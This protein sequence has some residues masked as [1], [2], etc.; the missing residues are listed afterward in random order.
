MLHRPALFL[1][2]IFWPLLTLQ[3]RAGATVDY[4]KEIRPLLEQKCYECHG[5]K[6]VKG[7]VDLKKLDGDPKFAT[8]YEVWEKVKEVITSGDMP[9][10]D[11]PA[12]PDA[13]RDK[14]LAWISHSLDDPIR[15]NAGDPGVVT[16]RR[17]TNSE[18]D[19]TLRDLTGLD[20]H[21][22]RDFAPDGGGGEGFTN[23]GDV[24][25]VSPQQLDKYFGAARKLADYATIMPG[26]GITFQKQR[27]GLRGPVQV[28]A[29]AEQG[30]YVWY[31]KMAEPI[32]PKDT[33]DAREADY[34][35]ACWKWKHRD[36]TGAVSLEQLAKDNGLM[37]PFLE[38]WWNL[39]TNVEPKSRYLDLTR[40]GWRQLPPPDAARP[41]EVPAAVRDRILALQADQRSWLGPAGKPGEGTQRHQQDSDGIHRYDF[42]A[43]VQGKPVVHIVLGDVAGDDNKGDWVTFDGLTL[44]HGKKKEA[45]LDWLQARL[46]A[47]K[48]ALAK[49]GA[50]AARLNARI[51]EAE[52]ALA[53]FGKDPRGGTARPDAIVAQ[54]PTVITLPLPEDATKFMA[55][56]KLDIDGPNAD[57]AGV[58]WMAT[59]DTPRD[60]HT[61]LPGILTVWK[62]GSSAT[63]RLGREFGIMKDAFPDEYLRRLE[64][65]ARNYERGGKGLGVYYLSDTQLL[66]LIPAEEKTH[67]EKMMADWKLVRSKEVSAPQGKEWDEAVKRHLVA[68]AT[69]A[70]RHDL[71]KDETAQITGLYEAARGRE[72]DRESAGREVLVRVLVSPN[73]LFK[74]EDATQPGIQPI[75][76]W[77]LAT[78]LSYF[79]WASA[80]DDALRAAAENGSLLKPEVLEQQAKRMLRDPRASALAEE[81]AGQWLKFNSFEDKAN[82]DAKKFPEFTP[83]LKHDMYRE[84]VEF[85][86][87]VIREDR[88][89]REIVSANYTFLNERL[90]KFYGIPGVTGDDFRL[91][92]VGEYQRGGVL[93]MGCLLA[94][95]SYPHRTSP[96]LRGNW[97]LVSV[98]G[99]PTPPPPNN[100][101]KLDDSVSAASTLRERLERHRQDKA[102]SVCHEKIDPLGFALEGFDP[103]GRAR[104]TDEAG[105]KIDN[106]GQ[107]KSSKPFVGVEGL[108]GF[109]A[110]HDKEFTTNFCRKLV[111][112]ALG[113]SLILTDKPLIE[114]MRTDLPKADDRFSVAVLDLVKSRQFQYRRND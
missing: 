57:L 75:T 68:F 84:T 16:I 46:R 96:V 32:L 10:D 54:A 59:A 64:E 40:V 34:M 67:W 53:K 27:V 58:Q 90:A 89:V 41:H 1:P 85:F 100:V 66:S 71:N 52:T 31:Q 72:L 20:L 36:V 11:K 108:R 65:V 60:P 61:V 7:G 43:D 21:L 114:Q 83:E 91:V 28:K 55:G 4:A 88:P 110:E 69:R 78:R 56:G 73:F 22:A 12:L 29:Q 74:L 80:P 2:L 92:P 35:T 103:I 25:F 76:A 106:S 17:L 19:H 24:L 111:G 81:F 15:A 14:A 87:H 33:D 99:L 101:P 62:R 49:P 23:V 6:K 45:Y 95:T 109:L 77:E 112:Y 105:L 5:G 107:W 9:P 51:Q 13:E 3:A 50:D 98:L 18:Y 82:I 38:N 97:L 8:E 48:E 26:S 42:H 93:G 86:A 113:R 102:C 30:L 39:L 44:Q 47:D 70:W 37:L 104:A 79:L 63:G 94:K